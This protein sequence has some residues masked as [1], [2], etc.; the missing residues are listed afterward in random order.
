M[1]ESYGLN[2]QPACSYLHINERANQ[3]PVRKPRK[4]C[5]QTKPSAS[6]SIHLY[7]KAEHA[8]AVFDSAVRGVRGLSL[9]GFVRVSV[10]GDL[11][12][13]QL[14]LRYTARTS[15]L[16]DGERRGPDE[17]NHYYNCGDRRSAR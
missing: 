2:D 5:R 6:K 3:S 13:Q 14:F 4:L 7:H 1:I 16:P 15:N 12:I 17:K 10:F 11:R 8:D 9:N